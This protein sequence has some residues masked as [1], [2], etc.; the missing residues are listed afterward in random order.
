MPLFLHSHEHKVGA[1]LAVW[2]CEVERGYEVNIS[3]CCLLAGW[4]WGFP[5]VLY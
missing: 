2:A 3:L 4:G 1:Y 5:C